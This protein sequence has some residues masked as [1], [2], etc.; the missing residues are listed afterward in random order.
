M[1][2]GKRIGRWPRPGEGDT[3]HPIATVT[4]HRAPLDGIVLAV[5]ALCAIPVGAI[6]A[7]IAWRTLTTPA[8]GWAIVVFVAAAGLLFGTWATS[9][10]AYRVEP[11]R[12]VVERPLGEIVYPLAGLATVTPH[13][14]W[15][16]AIRVGNGG[17]FGITGWFWSRSLGWFR[18][19]ARKVRGAVLLRW[20]DRRVVVMPEDRDAFIRDVE[21]FAPKR[22]AV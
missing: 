22:E 10:T 20:P 2:S 15:G 8:D 21:R 17:L 13:E 9:P 11:D 14:R 7:V 3:R 19:H 1:A 6:A 5:T 16:L 18:V 4:R 12:L